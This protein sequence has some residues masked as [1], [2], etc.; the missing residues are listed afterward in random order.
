MKVT[1]IIPTYNV[2]SLWQKWIE[3]YQ[4]QSLKADQVIV[5]DSSSTDQTAV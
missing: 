4:N 2:G 3:A 1:V 5:I